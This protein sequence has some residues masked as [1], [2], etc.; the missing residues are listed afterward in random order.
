MTRSLTVSHCSP[1]HSN[2]E[3]RHLRGLLASRGIGLLCGL[4]VLGACDAA[5]PGSPS[6]C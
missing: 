3:N 2:I 6:R 4:L 5:Q 1:R